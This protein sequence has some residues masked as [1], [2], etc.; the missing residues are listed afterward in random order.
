MTEQNQKKTNKIKSILKWIGL[1]LL[2]LLLIIAFTF[3]IPWKVTTLLVIVLLACTIL[4]SRLRKWFWLSV[5]VVLIALLVW[6]LLPD[7]NDTWRPYTFDEELAGHEAKYAVAKE[8]NA[9][10]I[11]NRLLKDY[12]PEEMKL[13][14]LRPGVREV[15]LSEPWLSQDHPKLVQWLDKHNDTVNKLQQIYKVKRC[16]FSSIFKLTI[17]KK[18]EILRYSALKSWAVLLLLSG[19]NDMAEDRL[20]EALWKYACVQQMANHLYQQKRMIDFL[21]G[22][23]I[24]GLA[25]PPLNRFVIEGR[26]S[27]EQLQLVSDILGD[28]ENNWYS[29]C[30]ECLEY[31]KLFF[32]NIFCSF[33]YQT[34]SKGRVRLS[35]NPAE[36]IWPNLLPR[37]SKEMYSQRKSMKAYTILAWFFFPSTPQKADKM[38]NAIYD[39]FDAM[40]RPGFAWDKENIASIDSLTLN[41]RFLLTLLTSKSTRRYNGFHDIYLKHVSQRRALRLLIAIKQYN[42]KNG[43]WPENLD[44]IKFSVPAEAFIDPIN[45]NSFI[46]KLTD[47]SFT[48]YSKGKNNIDENGKRDIW[49]IQDKGPDDW[50]FWPQ[51]NRNIKGKN[52][53]EE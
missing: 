3:Q 2:A 49:S 8:E 21:M 42:I 22:F 26:P 17:T 30:F 51:R 15:T 46:Y 18:Q 50:L 14:F 4:P 47:D 48:L 10:T 25:L 36:V 31:D 53:D 27:E 29:D 6:V 16:R 13:R 23:G 38:I 44:A 1:I 11:Y 20:D 45:N 9:A 32:K 43:C 5:A 34:N 28:L 39:K 12:N 52:T 37:D 7:G 35:R 41:C 40:T 24:E 19:N 33:V